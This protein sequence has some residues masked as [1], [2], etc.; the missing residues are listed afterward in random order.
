MSC[1]VYLAQITNSL[2]P[3]VFVCLQCR[4]RASARDDNAYPTTY[5][6]EGLCVTSCSRIDQNTEIQFYY[7]VVCVHLPFNNK[8]IASNITI[9]NNKYKNNNKQTTYNNNS[10]L[11][12]TFICDFSSTFHS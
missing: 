8:K 2:L 12:S 10:S 7:S 4:E 9:N 5:R 11:T 1:P 3:P 6:N